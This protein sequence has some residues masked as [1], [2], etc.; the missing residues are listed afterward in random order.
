M[1]TCHREAAFQSRIAVI[2]HG[3]TGTTGQNLDF[4]L[5][6]TDFYNSQ[7]R[8]SLYRIRNRRNVAF[9]SVR[10]SIDGIYQVITDFFRYHVSRQFYPFGLELDAF[11]NRIKLFL[12]YLLAFAYVSDNIF[13]FCFRHCNDDFT[14]TRNSVTHVSTYPRYQTSLIVSNHLIQ[15]TSHQLIGIGKA[16]TDLDTGMSAMQSFQGHLQSHI[17]RVGFFFL[18]L[19]GS[20][21][22]LTTGTTDVEF[23][24]FFRIQVQQDITFDSSRFQ[25]ECTVHARFF[26]GSNQ[27]YQRTVLQSLVLHHGHDGG[28]PHTVIGTQCSTFCSYPFPIDI[29]LDRIFFKIMAS[30]VI[31]LRN[32]IHVCLQD[33][34]LAVFH[35]RSSRLTVNDVSGFI[36]K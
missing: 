26:I 21:Q 1:H 28:Y 3:L 31:L 27:T 25:T 17:R 4:G 18:V 12:P 35:P 2:L 29:G 23:T 13:H 24:F 36:L 10:T 20:C 7:V 22:I 8:R 5:S 32:H 15:K 11:F 6:S 30:I 16:T 34:S 9:H 33:N 19:Q 14:F